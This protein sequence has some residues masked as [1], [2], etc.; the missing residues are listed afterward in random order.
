MLK[1]LLSNVHPPMKLHK[2]GSKPIS[3]GID[4]I[5]YDGCHPHKVHTNE[6]Q[7]KDLKKMF[8]RHNFFEK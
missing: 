3:E 1:F 2:L 8:I 7:N 4:V 5:Y 6:I